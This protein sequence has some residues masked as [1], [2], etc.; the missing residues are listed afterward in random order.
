MNPIMT[1]T[2]KAEMKT[3][4]FFRLKR[5]TPEIMKSIGAIVWDWQ[6]RGH[7]VIVSMENR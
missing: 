3:T 7:K 2:D 1:I 6:N 4:L 5:L